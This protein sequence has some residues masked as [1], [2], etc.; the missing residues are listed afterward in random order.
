MVDKATIINCE[1]LARSAVAL[2]EVNTTDLKLNVQI[3]QQILHNL[4]T[5]PHFPFLFLIIETLPRRSFSRQ[6]TDNNA[7]CVGC[8]YPSPE[9]VAFW[10]NRS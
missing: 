7:W 4:G 1:Y 3:K 2:S 10:R 5:G 8:R 9:T 6:P